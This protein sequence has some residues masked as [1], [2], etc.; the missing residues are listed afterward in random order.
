MTA[1]NTFNQIK[2]SMKVL[3]ELTEV[4]CIHPVGL[5]VSMNI[6]GHYS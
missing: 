5:S 1:A 2:D 6:A 4:A 3:W